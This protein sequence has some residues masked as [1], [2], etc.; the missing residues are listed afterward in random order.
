ML[1]NVLPNLE[2]ENRVRKSFFDRKFVTA[3]SCASLLIALAIPFMSSSP[4]S[5]SDVAAQQTSSAVT[6]VEGPQPATCGWEVAES[7]YNRVSGSSTNYGV[8]DLNYDT[9]T[10]DVYGSLSTYIANCSSSGVGCGG[11]QIERSDA[12]YET[13]Q[14]PVG[15]Y[16]C[17]TPQLSDAGYT[18]YAVSSFEV[19]ASESAAATTGSF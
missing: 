10:R 8:T 11:L 19:S 7:A 5:A 12:N 3:V 13:C 14:I 18:T 15:V 1:Q 9:C 2:M 17:T 4:A 16:Y 6:S